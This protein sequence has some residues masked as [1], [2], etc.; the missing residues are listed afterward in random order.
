[1]PFIPHTEGDTKAMLETLGVPSIDSLF[2]EIPEGFLAAPLELAKGESEMALMADF[3]A[4][5]R[6]DDNV[7]CFAG[8]GAYDH[9]IPS[10]VWDL[11]SRGEIMTAYTPY[12][13]EASQGTLQTIYEYQ[14]MIA[15]LTGMDV[16]NASVY[17]GGSGLAE[18]ALM[19]V[20]SA[21]RKHARTLLLAGGLNPRY[22]AACEA[23]VQHQGLTL[24]DL[25]SEADGSLCPA[26]LEAAMDE[27]CAA[28]VISQPNFFGVL[29]DVHALT[30]RAQAAGLLVIAVVNPIALAVLTP[31]GAWG[32][33]G[34]DIVVGDGQPLGIPMASGGP[35][36]GFLCARQKLVRQMPGRIV[37]R[38]VDLEGKTGYALTLQAREQHIRRGK[39]TSNI[40]TNQGLLMTAGTIYMALLG[41]EGLSRVA[42]HC[43]GQLR[44]LLQALT[45]L[46][47]VR[48]VHSG[49][50]FH[51]AVIELPIPAKAV[52]E[53]LAERRILPG[54]A[55]SDFWPERTHELLVCATE[56]RTAEDIAQYREALGQVLEILGTEVAQ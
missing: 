13:A 8:A 43:Y 39:A 42:G 10:A 50:H 35:Y 27:D 52:V 15:K 7:L 45:S 12:Q 1:M 20:R 21:P 25:P 46:P 47:G 34:A 22:R 4:R 2:D 17:D 5:A 23:I 41:P 54:V 40:C 51:E 26:T 30:D 32:S 48:S 38:T 19:A 31:P 16:A 36:F 6:R 55:L 9:H 37:G 11:V 28:L 53:A 56:K 33:A 14:S 44:A 3:A 29:E 24:R 49:V 18:A